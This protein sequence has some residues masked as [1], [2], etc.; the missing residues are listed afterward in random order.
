MK[1]TSYAKAQGRADYCH[2]HLKHRQFV[3]GGHVVQAG[4]SSDSP[5][6][7]PLGLCNWVRWW[8]LELTYFIMMIL[9]LL[10]WPVKSSYQQAFL[11]SSDSTNEQREKSLDRSTGMEQKHREKYTWRKERERLH[12]EGGFWC[13]QWH[14]LPLDTHEI[15]RCTIPALWGL[16][17]C[18]DIKHRM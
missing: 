1:Q 17:L 6:E 5:R 13:I 7:C 8:L 12:Q 4:S 14:F 18:K 2:Q 3:R 11:K 10:L 16:N 9:E 15:I